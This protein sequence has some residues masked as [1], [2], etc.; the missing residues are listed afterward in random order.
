MYRMV[1][2]EG[3][4]VYLLTL[5]KREELVELLV[6]LRRW[7]FRPTR[8]APNFDVGEPR[9][10]L[11]LP[12]PRSAFFEAMVRL[13]IADALDA[14]VA[15]VLARGMADAELA[16]SV[17]ALLSAAAFNPPTCDTAL[18]VCCCHDDQD[19]RATQFHVGGRDERRH[20]TCKA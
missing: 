11:E 20:W 19:H 7:T 3:R 17:C 16:R 14:E 10:H 18:D 4:P 12:F 2:R 6:Y 15:A 1:P 8:Y 13:E 9:N 5:R